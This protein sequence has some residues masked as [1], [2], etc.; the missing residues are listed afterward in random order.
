MSALSSADWN[1]VHHWPGM[2]MPS[3][4]RCAWPPAVS[5]AVVAAGVLP[6]GGKPAARG[7]AG[8]LKLGPTAQA[9]SN[10]VTAAAHAPARTPFGKSFFI[11]Q[12]PYRADAVPCSAA[13]LLI[14]RS[15]V[16][17]VTEAENDIHLPL[18]NDMR[19]FAAQ[20]LFTNWLFIAKIYYNEWLVCK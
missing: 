8:A 2:S 5:A 12:M 20:E 17:R 18:K 13:T 3:T 9:A 16:R 15:G 1:K 4:K 10:P 19:A 7:A 6:G 14:D 11:C